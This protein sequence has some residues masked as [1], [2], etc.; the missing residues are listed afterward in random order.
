ME[1]GRA[2][3]WDGLVACAR[4]RRSE[5]VFAA[6][7]ILVGAA[8]RAWVMAGPLG[9]PDLDEATVGVQAQEFNAG[10]LSVFFLNQPYGGTLEPGLVA[11][12]FR[13]FGASVFVLKLVPILFYAATAVLCWRLAVRVGL[14]PVGRASTALL[15]WC[16]PAYVVFFSTKERGFYGVAALLGVVYPLLVLRLAERRRSA[17]V[18]RRDLLGLGLCVGLGWWQTPLVVLVAVPA[19]GWLVVR[20]PEVV[21]RC[22]WAIG[23]AVMGALPWL[24]WNVRNG[25]A[26]LDS[27]PPM[28]ASW[29][30]RVGDFWKRLSVMTGIETPFVPGRA[31]MDWEWAGAVLVVAVLVVA[32]V[33][34]RR[35]A[36]G[37]LATL[38]VGYSLLYGLNVLVELVGP[39]PR[40]LFLVVPL[41]AVCVG[42][43]VPEVDEGLGRSALL[44]GVGVVTVALSVWGIVG[45]NREAERP[46]ASFFLSS[47]GIEDVAT[48][49]EQRDVEAAITDAAG[50]Q[51][52]FLTGGRVE[53]SSFA[54]VRLRR[55]EERARRASP[56]TYVLDRHSSGNA[57][58]LRTWLDE[59][60]IGYTEEAV[61]IWRVFFL[62]ERVLPEDV[63]LLIF[64]GLPVRAPE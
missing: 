37:L 54:V 12:A 31:L 7:V 38:I 52:T 51:I 62:T 49:L 53:G 14:G 47:P 24:V 58:R 36:S 25:W 60:H 34:T 40:Y 18:D 15:A 4:E 56:S 27:G 63:P 21:R 28:G 13:L 20:R 5:L 6:V 9:S 33:R 8:L 35:V 10:R 30:E 1:E 45:L 64:L 29:W 39:D 59:R 61:G 19:V 48:L 43:M 46:G 26:S 41:L 50:M 11:I 23:A 16:G 57:D 2:T 32:T 42:A 22:G 3:G 44:G 17:A 55:L